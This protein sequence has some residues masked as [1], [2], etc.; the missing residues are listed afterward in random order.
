MTGGP[1]ADFHRNIGPGQP[2]PDQGEN[3]GQAPPGHF[4]V[5]RTPQALPAASVTDNAT[6]LLPTTATTTGESLA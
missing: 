6:I 4:E 2:V 3:P 5:H 1:D